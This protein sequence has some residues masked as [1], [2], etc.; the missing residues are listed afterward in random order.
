MHICFASLDYPD[1]TGGGGVGTYVQ[2]LGHELV[3]RGHKVSAIAL[4]NDR[5]P[6]LSEDGGIRVCWVNSGNVHWY[7]STLPFIGKLFSLPLRELEYSWAVLKAIKEIDATAPID[8][9]EGIETGACGFRFLRPGI[10]TVVRLHGEAYSCEKYTPPG[11]IP[12]G[13]LLSRLLQRMA[14]RKAHSL[15]APSRS[16]AA[17]IEHEIGLPPGTVSVIM[18]PLRPEN[19][20]A[21]TQASRPDN[22]GFLFVGRIDRR[23]GVLELLKAIPGI[24]EKLPSADFFFAGQFHPSIREKEVREL[25]AELGISERVHFLGYVRK[26]QIGEHYRKATAVVIPSFYESFGY[27]YLEALM[28]G[29]PVIAFDISAAHNF[30][31]PGQS[32]CLVP[33]GDVGALADA[34]VEAV[35]M[36]VELPDS[37][38][39][40]EFSA[41]RIGGEMLAFYKQLPPGTRS[42]LHNHV[43]FLSPHFDDAVFSCGGIMH[44]YG[45]QGKSNVIVT[46][47]GG[48]PDNS[49]LSPFAREIHHKWNLTDPVSVRMNEDRKALA[50]IG[51]QEIHLDFLDCIYRKTEE[52][53]PLYTDYEGI[54]KALH[55][56]DLK[57]CDDVYEQVAKTLRRYDPERT[58][59]LVPLGIGNHVDHQIAHKVGLRLIAEGFQIVFYEEFPYSM[60]YPE[61][62]KTIGAGHENILSPLVVF[63]EMK[64]KLKMIRYYTSQLSGIG[65]NYKKASGH[66]KHY[67]LTVGDGR[68]AERI[69]FPATS[70]HEQNVSGI[71]RKAR[72]NV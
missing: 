21:E 71:S 66:F 24:V 6:Y 25:V 12:T 29:K 38:R 68:P 35:S 50:T 63:I 19:F 30:I 10:K 28:H 39:R 34:C 49:H 27:I 48:V 60:W 11:K 40:E 4:R 47:F 62:L 42:G 13:I 72:Q 67:A 56:R 44:E 65:G 69:W 16:H 3:R 37:K 15:S 17:E 1:E 61:E 43:V 55:P 52:G 31:V 58:Q 41:E 2:T 57:L 22:P 14:I 36:K 8:I 20:T 51:A 5:E 70:S 23:K 7:L 53:V 64:A 45:K 54:R 32:G 33:P 18:N 26:D 46:L 9:V 59:V